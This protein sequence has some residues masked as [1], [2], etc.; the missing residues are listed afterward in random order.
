MEMDE[1]WKPLTGHAQYL[2]SDRGR[3]KRRD[4]GVVYAGSIDNHGYRRFDLCENGKRFFV[5]AHRAVAEAFLERDA[6]RNQVNHIDGNKTNNNVENLEWC[7]SK[8]NSI[9]AHSIL[10]VKQWNENQVLCCETGIVFESCSDAA[11]KMYGK[12]K[13]TGISRCCSGK[14]KTYKGMHWKYL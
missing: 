7:T 3:I 14:R 9:H 2:V 8:E 6:L 13:D 5:S 10:N 11:R 4:S 1:L 12:E